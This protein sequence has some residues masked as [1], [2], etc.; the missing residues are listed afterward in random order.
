MKRELY[1]FYIDS[2]YRYVVNGPLWCLIIAVDFSAITLNLCHPNTKSSQPHDTLSMWLP[3]LT[4][5][6]LQSSNTKLSQVWVPHFKKFL[7]NYT[8]FL[9]HLFQRI[10]LFT[11]FWKLNPKNMP[12]MVFIPSAIMTVSFAVLHSQSFSIT[13]FFNILSLIKG[14]QW[15]HF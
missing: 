2:M 9:F 6:K 8:H 1:S 13:S 15:S 4:S 11:R 5:R 3:I 7:R 10:T 12:F 14:N